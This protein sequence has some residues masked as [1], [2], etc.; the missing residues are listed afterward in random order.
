M[1]GIYF[2]CKNQKHSIYNS[3]SHPF[4]NRLTISY[5]F[6]AK[7]AIKSAIAQCSKDMKSISVIYFGIDIYIMT[8]KNKIGAKNKTFIN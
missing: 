6:P 5:I 2:S 4:D 1:F 8:G 7:P 3:I